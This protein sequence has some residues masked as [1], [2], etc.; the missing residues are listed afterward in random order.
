MNCVLPD[1]GIPHRH[2]RGVQRQRRGAD[3]RRGDDRFPLRHPRCPGA[4]RY[5]GGPDLHWA[6]SSAAAC[7][8]AHSGASARSWNRSPR[9]DPCTR[10]APC[11]GNPIAMAAGLATMRHHL[12]TRLLRAAVRA[13]AAALRGACSAAP[14]LPAYP[15]PPTTRAPCSAASSPTSDTVTNYAEVMACDTG[16]LRAL[17]PHDARPRGIH[18]SGVL[19]GGLHVSGAHGCRY[20]ADRRGRRHGI[21]AL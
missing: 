19:R 3:P 7:P 14:T 17:L 9:W 4:F 2:A 20:R 6:R 18:G 13:H 5:R 10:P 11:P 21:R 8:S 16:R 1:A 12:P 15:L